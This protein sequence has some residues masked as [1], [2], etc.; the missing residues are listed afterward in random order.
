[1]LLAL[2]RFLALAAI[3][4]KVNSQLKAKKANPNNPLGR[5]L[6]F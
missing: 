3:T 1:M 5:V 6:G 2:W 4:A